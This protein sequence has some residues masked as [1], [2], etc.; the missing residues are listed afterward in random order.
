MHSL[1]WANTSSPEFRYRKSL[2]DSGP[3]GHL[4]DLS[5]SGLVAAQILV[6]A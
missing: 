4:N 3:D 6:R 2:E 5:P 1:Q